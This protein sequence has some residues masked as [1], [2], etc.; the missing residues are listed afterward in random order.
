MIL[1]G[2]MGPRVAD[3]LEASK[4]ILAIIHFSSRNGSLL[5]GDGVEFLYVQSDDCESWHQGHED[6]R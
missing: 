4:A 6:W 2:L 1:A 5:K 3:F